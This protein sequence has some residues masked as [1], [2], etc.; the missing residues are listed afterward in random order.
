MRSKTAQFTI[1]EK[2]I[3]NQETYSDITAPGTNNV[4]NPIEEDIEFLMERHQNNK[5]YKSKQ[6]WVELWSSSY[7]SHLAKI[8][9]N[10][11]SLIEIQMIL[12]LIY[13]IAFD[14]KNPYQAIIEC[15]TLIQMLDRKIFQE[16][17]YIEY[18]IVKFNIFILEEDIK[19]DPFPI[20]K[21]ML[22]DLGETEESLDGVMQESI[23]FINI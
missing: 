7:T 17:S 22:L 13:G 11:L 1:I 3:E 12:F 6:L 20:L 15:K 18:L 5:T 4:F 8:K 2:Q 19:E 10:K 21:K 9:D 16:N 14:L 23:S